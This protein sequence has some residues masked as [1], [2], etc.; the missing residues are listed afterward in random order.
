M[1]DHLVFDPVSGTL[2]LRIVN[3]S[4]FK[5]INVHID[6][7][8][9]IHIP[10]GGRHANARLKLKIDTM[11]ILHP[12][13][14]WNIATKPFLPQNE[15]GAKLDIKRFDG[16]RVYEF[17]PDLLNEIYR[18]DDTEIAKKVDYNNLNITITIKSPLFGTDWIYNRTYKTKDFVCG[19]LISVDP[20]IS[21]KNIT[22]WSNW[23]KYD[24][25]SKSYCKK[26]IF[27]NA[28]GIIKKNQTMIE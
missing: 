14:V 4:K 5:L 10:K 15:D 21:G 9:R 2:R 25:M 26:C 13:T 1:E 23:G 19:K 27:S 6:A 22:D 18:S 24:D 28:C 12:Y 20:H 16:D 17:I 3:R 7:Y 11:N 8:F